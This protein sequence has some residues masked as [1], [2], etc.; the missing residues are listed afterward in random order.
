[1]P[2]GSRHYDLGKELV[3][4]G[5]DVTII[6]SS[7]HYS[8]HT[9]MKL[10]KGERWKIESVDGV[11]FVWI[12]TIGYSG[13][14][15]RRIANMLSYTIRSYFLG[16]NKLNHLIPKPDIVIGSSVHLFAVLSAYYIARHYHARF[17]MEVRDLWPQTLVDMGA[18]NPKSLMARTMYA[19][20]K[21]LYGKAEKIITLLPSAS[22]YITKCGVSK[23]NVVWIPNC[24]DI[25]RFNNTKIPK[26]NVNGEFK[27]LY[28]GA[29]GQANNLDAVIDAA[30]IVQNKGF[31]NIQF[32]LVGHGT[33]KPR[34]IKRKQE[35]NLEI[36]EFR[37][38]IPKT[39]VPAYIELFDVCLFTL[40]DVDIYK[41]GISF[42]KVFDYLA[43][44]KPVIMAGNPINSIIE[45]ANCGIS[46]QPNNPDALANAVIELARLSSEERENM[47]Q[48][49][50]EY[51]EK[52]YDTRII[53]NK[54]IECIES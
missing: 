3:K 20:E 17:I 27:V 28:L 32:I 9:E 6:A 22:D 37:E 34:L 40:L 21:F 7:F 29:H 5:Y 26:A 46:V 4:K 54:L 10:S 13:N 51:V 36:I 24:V 14:N 33:E 35:M 12:K 15:W 19:L 50:R 43:S 49:G 18:L 52:L 1:M 8:K 48:K 25:A 38:P 30:K 53:A 16:I 2:G 23:E 45:E 31:K 39:E 47:G 44:G 42:N 11:R 41:Y